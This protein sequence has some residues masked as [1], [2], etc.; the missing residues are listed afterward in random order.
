MGVYGFD[1]THFHL[2]MALS[3]VISSWCL[4]PDL[5]TKSKPFYNWSHL[6]IFVSVLQRFTTHRGILHSCMFAPIILTFPVTILMMLSEIPVEILVP[7]YIGITAQVE[8]HILLDAFGS[9]LIKK[10]NK[11]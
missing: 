5:D 11:K 4:T 6:K 10:S 2:I 1:I 8:I 3:F 7:V 9:K